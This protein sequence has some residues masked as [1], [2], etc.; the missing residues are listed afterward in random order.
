M[1]VIMPFM[2]PFLTLGSTLQQNA[3]AWGVESPR[4]LS[5]GKGGA[6]HASSTTCATC[7][8]SQ[9]VGQ[10]AFALSTTQET[11]AKYV[12]KR[13]DGRQKCAHRAI[14]MKRR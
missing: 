10:M 14:E 4:L 8:K 7:A 2:F 9:Q 6:P 5:H 12:A 3:I 11:S 13:R 1:R